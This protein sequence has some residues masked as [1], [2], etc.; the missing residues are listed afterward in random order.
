[1]IGNV[2]FLK[3]GSTAFDSIS[4]NFLDHVMGF[5]GFGVKWRCWIK[6][7][8]FTAKI[9][10]LVNGSPS[11]QF[12]MERGLRQG[13]PFSPLLFNIA[14]EA[15][16]AMLCKVESIKICKGVMIGRNGLSLTHL[17]YADDTILFFNFTKSH[18]IG[19]GINQ[20]LVGRWAEKIMC[21]VG[22]LPTTYLGLPLGAKHNSTRF[23]D[24]VFEKVRRKLAGWK[25]KM[26]SFG[27]RI[28]LLKSI[29]TSMPVFYMS[30]FQVPHKVKNELKKLQRKFLWGGDDQKRKIHLVKWDKVCNYKDCGG[31][32]ITN[33]E[34]KNRAMLNKWIWRYGM[35]TDSL[36]RTV[37]V[38]KGSSNPSILLPNMSV[39]PNFGFAVSK[40]DNMLFWS[41]EWI[42][43]IILSQAFPRIFALAVNRNEVIFSG[44]EWNVDQC[45]DLVKVRVVS[46]SNAKWPADYS[47]VLDTYKEPLA[48]GQPRKNRKNIKNIL[49]TA[50]NER[51]LKFNVDGATQGCLGPAGIGGLLRNCKR[52]VKIIFSKHISEAD[53]NLAEYRAV[54]EA[55]AIF[56]ASKW[57][58]D[59]SLLIENNS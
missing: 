19:I 1:M 45:L 14:G 47:S 28:T 11:R 53:S 44:K 25:T 12:N 50:P 8:I 56:V 51:T 23:W 48:C 26:L 22:Y 29:L 4:W 24:L 3:F 10:I 16:S 55:F 49:W 18:L 27:G 43:G 30:L 52:E 57:K 37:I 6:D 40:G 33:I 9:S 5:I 7:C 34:I 38:D 2:N 46:W 39:V 20:M 58:E 21:K 13:C 17:Q 59:Y 42:D 35:E 32:G 41:D 15:L 31:I 54:R 36:W